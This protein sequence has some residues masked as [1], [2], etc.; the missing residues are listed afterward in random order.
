MSLLPS[1]DPAVTDADPRVISVDSDD[2]DDV[3]SALSAATARK[4]LAEIH[5]EPA[6]PGELADRVD[7]SLQNAQYH[8]EKLETAGAVE[9]ADTAYSE[10]G[11]EMDVY[12]PAD[13]PL[14]ICAGDEQETSGLRSAVTSL[15]G[16]VAVVGVLS[17]FVQELLGRSLLGSGVQ[18]GSAGT[19]Q[20]GSS[21]LPSGSTGSVTESAGQVAAD[22]GTVAQSGAQAAVNAVPP[23]AAFFAGGCVVLL[24]MFAV[25]HFG[26]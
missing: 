14:V 18:E 13:Q 25:W 3:L 15:L 4:L 23:G 12:A 24:A 19:G 2:A 1:K 7:T 20:P 10:K 16:G 9:V 11:R 8:L 17:L 6:P 22:G 21:Y 26:R 5:E